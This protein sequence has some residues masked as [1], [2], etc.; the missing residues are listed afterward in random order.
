[1]L[2]GKKVK[3]LMINIFEIP[4]IPYWFTLKQAVGIIHHSSGKYAEGA[5]PMIILVFEEKYN[6][7]GIAHIRDILKGLEPKFLKGSEMFKLEDE[8]RAE[9]VLWNTVFDS[10]SIALAQK[11]ISEVMTPVKHL[12]SPD[13]YIT[14]AAH[15]LIHHNLNI[16][17]VVEDK[18]KLV[19]VVRDIDIF[20]EVAEAIL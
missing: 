7:V 16:L 6:L 13:E 8:H 4:H 18:K 19:G 20:R 5:Y 10:S 12:V 1:M 9:S 17:P 11:P 2:K 3:D 15:L 14:T